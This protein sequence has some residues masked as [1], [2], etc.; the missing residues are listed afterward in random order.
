MDSLVNRGFLS[1]QESP[2]I[3]CETSSGLT[4]GM[5][6]LTSGGPIYDTKP[7]SY[8]FLMFLH[9]RSISGPILDVSFGFEGENLTLFPPTLNPSLPE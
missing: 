7:L 2:F 8:F 5:G 1:D 3:F 6:P 4:Q 9:V